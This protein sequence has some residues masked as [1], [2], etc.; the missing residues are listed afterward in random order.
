MEK[1]LVTCYS[2]IGNCSFNSTVCIL[3]ST[4]CLI[5]TNPQPFC[6]LLVDNG[7]Y[8]GQ[9]AVAV[10]SVKL[11]RTTYCTFNA[12]QESNSSTPVD[13]STLQTRG[14]LRSTPPA[15]HRKESDFYIFI[16]AVTLVFG[17]GLIFGTICTY[18]NRKIHVE[19]QFKQR[20]AYQQKNACSKTSV[21]EIKTHVH[22]GRSYETP[23][24]AASTASHVNKCEKS[25]WPIDAVDDED[26]STAEDD[27]DGAGD[28][29]GLW[30]EWF[31]ADGSFS[32]RTERQEEKGGR[33]SHDDNNDHYYDSD[34][35]PESD[36]MKRKAICF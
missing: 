12:A 15:Y 14:R 1:V 20:V 4:F 19:H 3:N 34:T 27:S 10:T 2:N 16:G 31:L 11:N 22:L 35:T 9:Y 6:D 32:R 26:T 8:T 18:C 5:L 21:G 28:E 24:A 23:E 13:T 30:S 7:T 36:R 25:Y 29:F 17:L 33:M